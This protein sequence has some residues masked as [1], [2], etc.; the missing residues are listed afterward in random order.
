MAE[1]KVNQEKVNSVLQQLKQRTEAI[2]T[3]QPTLDFSTS[4]LNFLDKISSIETTYYQALTQY[5]TTLLKIE[6]D[7]QANIK[8]YLETDERI[9]QK[10][11]TK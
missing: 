3:T 8:T 9:A 1:I 4:S 6:E 2:N 10:I 11:E 5:K 7:I